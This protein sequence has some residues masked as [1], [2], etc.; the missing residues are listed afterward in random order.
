MLKKSTTALFILFCTHSLGCQAQPLGIAFI[1][2]S[3]KEHVSYFTLSSPQ[4][5]NRS[6]TIDVEYR[7]ESGQEVCC[8]RLSGRLFN[9]VESTGRVSAKDQEAPIY[10]YQMPSRNLRISTDLTGTAVLNADST[11]RLG[12]GTI[13]A[14]NEGKTFEIER[15]YGIEG[16]NLFMKH[17][18]EI[19]E[20]LYL[21]LNVDIESTCQQV[22][23]HFSYT[24]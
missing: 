22:F 20:H 7:T 10:T 8:Q 4:K 19:V 1:E 9:E 17:N 3:P 16:I 11:R 14:R 21:Y 13:T 12:A 2:P 5:L 23:Q 6:S 18:G 15:C 24:K